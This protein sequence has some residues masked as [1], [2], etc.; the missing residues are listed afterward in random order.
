MRCAT[1]STAVSWYADPECKEPLVPAPNDSPPYSESKTPDHIA[2]FYVPGE[3]FSGQL[4]ELGDTA[5]PCRAFAPPRIPPPPSEL[6][7]GI[8]VSPDVFVE[9]HEVVLP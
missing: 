9:F 3:P 5:E 1:T 6:F 2:H 4:Y 8:E 7:R